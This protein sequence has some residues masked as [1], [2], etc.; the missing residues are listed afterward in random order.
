MRLAKYFF[1]IS[2]LII[3]LIASGCFN[4]ESSSLSEQEGKWALYSLEYSIEPKRSGIE[5]ILD[6]GA[7]NVSGITLRN[8]QL[9][10]ITSDS[11]VLTLG[12]GTIE[13]SE[14]GPNKV[15]GSIARWYIAN[16]SELL[17]DSEKT[18]EVIEDLEQNSYIIVK[19]QQDGDLFETTLRK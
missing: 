6:Y 7:L 14:L 2:S 9:E 11:T 4:E 15:I 8:I 3:L 12:N 17:D 10:L 16:H 19:W 1:L 13:G 5:V 18:K